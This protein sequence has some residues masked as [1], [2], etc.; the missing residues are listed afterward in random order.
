VWG[1]SS[2][3]LAYRAALEIA[4]RL[5]PAKVFQPPSFVTEHISASDNIPELIAMGKDRLMIWGA[6]TDALYGLVNLMQTAW[7]DIGKIKVPAAYLYGA[8]DQIIPRAPA[9]QAAARLP[10]G[11]RTAYYAKGWHLLLRD[12]QR[13]A[14]FDD[15]AAFIRDP[16]A[17][18]P[19]GARAIPAR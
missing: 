8:H 11:D 9:V 15:V 6:R 13:D 12:L 16:A 2:Q 1:W 14:V 19:S 7:R 3:P 17:P 10:A 5:A 18:W 4:V